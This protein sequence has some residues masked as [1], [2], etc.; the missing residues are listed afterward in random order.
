MAKRLFLSAV[1]LLIFFHGVDAQ[2]SRSSS[3]YLELKQQD[4]IFFE[5]GFNQCDMVYLE[6]AV[7][8]DLKF[9]HDQSGFQDHKAFFENTRKY[10]CTDPARKPIRRVDEESLE[11]YPLYDKGILYGAIHQGVHHFYI[12]EA[13]KKDLWTATARFTSVWVKDEGKWKLSEVLSY[14]HQEPQPRGKRTDEMEQLLKKYLVPAMGLGVIEGGKLTKIEVFGTLDGERTAP[15][16]TIFKVASLTKPVV[17]LTTL[18]LIDQGLLHLEEPLYKYWVDPDLKKDMRVKK[19]TP[20]LVLSHQTGFPNWRYSTAS[21]RLAFEFEPG[22]KYQYSGEGF[23][24]LRKAI[25][26]K[27]GK[28]FEEIAREL[29]LEPAGMTDTR[30]WWDPSMDESRYARNFD[31]SGNIIPTEK[32]FQANAAANLLTTVEDYGKFLAYVLD[33]AGLSE[34]VLNEMHRSQVHIRENDYFG[35][36]WEKLTRFSHGEYALM[37]TGRDPGVST[38]AIIFPNSKNGYLIF[39]NGGK[40]DKVYEEMLTKHLYLGGELWDKR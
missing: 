34:R 31:G 1:I 18:K 11:A 10:L 22:A 20:R 33:G 7:A 12:R 26:N 23:E 38:L 5:K 19:L 21:N 30:F 35:L 13:G 4:S 25:E 14:D 9:Y 3:L 29:V 15:Y 17:A 8:E 27:L 28:S 16:N 37:H 39:M 36:G 32:Y 6:K 2:I 24:Y 40:V